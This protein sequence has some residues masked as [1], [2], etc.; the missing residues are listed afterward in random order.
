MVDNVS[1]YQFLAAVRKADIDKIAQYIS[2]GGT[3][4]DTNPGGAIR[5]DDGIN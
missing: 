1:V 4:N 3:V 5:A 2:Q